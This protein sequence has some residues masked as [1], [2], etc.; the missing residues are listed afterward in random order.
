MVPLSG[1]SIVY[2][3]YCMYIWYPV[4]HSATPIPGTMVIIINL[5]ARKSNWKNG[6]VVV[7]KIHHKKIGGEVQ[8]Q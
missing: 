1:G 4:T 8:R 6:G 2:T 7:V 5:G 3:V